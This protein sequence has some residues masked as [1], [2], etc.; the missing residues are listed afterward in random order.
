M[1]ESKGRYQSASEDIACE[2]FD[3]E[4]VVLN[5]ASGHY[6]ALNQSASFLMSGLLRGHAIDSLASINEAAFN[7]QDATQF[8][9]ELVS[10]E[11][12][13]ADTSNEPK[14]ID[15]ATLEAAK[16]LTEKPQLEVHDDLADLIVAD[17]IHDTDEAVGWPAPAPESRKSA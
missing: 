14:P 10:H 4:M 11:L 13:V 9:E 3:G 12:I 17:P 1:S 6:F 5:L 8:V 7:S 16:A 2:E 15:A